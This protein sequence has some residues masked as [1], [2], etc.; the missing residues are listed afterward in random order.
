[1]IFSPG[2]LAAPLRCRWTPGAHCRGGEGAVWGFVGFSE[3]SQASTHEMSVVPPR[4]CPKL[5]PD[6]ARYSL[7]TPGRTSDTKLSQTGLFNRMHF[8]KSIFF[9]G[10]LVDLNAMKN[11]DVSYFTYFGGI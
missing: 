5:F 7:G 10:I 2:L 11:N 1:M 6:V 4:L 3:T 9:Q 8:C